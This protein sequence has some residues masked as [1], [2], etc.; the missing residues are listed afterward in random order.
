MHACLLLF[1]CSEQ[2]TDS[3]NATRAGEQKHKTH[4]ML[5]ESVQ[6]RLEFKDCRKGGWT[7]YDGDYKI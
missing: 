4:F 3:T 5:S 2:K 1:E 6:E 7:G